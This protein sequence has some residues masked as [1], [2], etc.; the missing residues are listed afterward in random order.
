[1]SVN[2]VLGF[3]LSGVDI[4]INK[5]YSVIYIFNASTIRGRSGKLTYKYI[6][7]ILYVKWYSSYELIVKKN[8]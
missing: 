5:M 7:V 4:K 6:I 2:C 1:M 8:M 3:L